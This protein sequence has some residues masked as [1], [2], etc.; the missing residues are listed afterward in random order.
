[1]NDTNPLAEALEILQA[2]MDGG[3][4]PACLVR[5]HHLLTLTQEQF[6][7]CPTDVAE[8]PQCPHCGQPCD[9]D[10]PYCSPQCLDAHEGWDDI[11]AD[12]EAEQFYDQMQFRI[13]DD[14]E[15]PSLC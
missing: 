1:M 6:F 2:L 13:A 5:V 10:L 7:T 9:A 15:P 14:Q 12:R 8:I 3:R 4:Y 11:A